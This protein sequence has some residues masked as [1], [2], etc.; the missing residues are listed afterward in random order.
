M[1]AF[2]LLAFGLISAYEIGSGLLELAL[3][4]FFAPVV[5]MKDPM[6][7]FSVSETKLHNPPE[8][9]QPVPSAVAASTTDEAPVGL[10]SNLR[11]WELQ[12]YVLTS[13]DGHNFSR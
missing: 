12:T 10:R 4:G 11:V 5:E 3:L 8:K 2:L 6:M 1:Y 13:S 7:E 9:P